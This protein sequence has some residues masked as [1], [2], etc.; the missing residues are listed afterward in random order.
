M[1][2]VTQAALGAA[3]GAAIAGKTL[4]RS[5]LLGGALLGTLPDMDVLIDYGS[6]VAN[7]TQ[8]RGFSH[9][10]LVLLPLSIVLAWFFH[11]WR[12]VLS[13]RRW[14]AF[15]AIV[16]ITHPLLD[17]FTTYGTQL[18]WPLG[19]PL[20]INSIFIIDPMYT[21]PLLLA[22]AWTLWRPR[23]LGAVAIGL[24]LSTA[25]LG[26]TLVAQQMIAYK[27][28]PALAAVGAERAPRMIQPMPLSTLLWRVTVMADDQRLEIVTGFLDGDMPLRI[29]RFDRH[30]DL[31]AATRQL[32]EGQRLI[33]FTQG[34]LNYAEREDGLAVTDIRLGVPGA[35]P[36]TFILAE[37]ADGDARWQTIPSY[38]INRPAIR[39]ELL[40]A[41]WQRITGATVLCLATLETR[42]RNEHCG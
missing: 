29:E 16:L 31:E 27:V 33:W 22:I 41:L 24:T 21:L 32:L 8:H 35:H 1:D 39:E 30:P 37:P 13:Y 20:A 34:F 23:Q 17:T 38:Q 26:W 36:F 40:G 6:A 19:R 15:T 10:L 18:F 25:Y 3:L 12:P 11:R 28:T 4:G 42:Q 5:A 7:F 9:S 14:F 2:S